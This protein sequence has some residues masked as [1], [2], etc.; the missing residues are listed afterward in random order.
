MF[1]ILDEGLT[2]SLLQQKVSSSACC[3]AAAEIR[4]EDAGFN[5]SL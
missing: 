4:Y 5:P 1:V 3:G 2:L